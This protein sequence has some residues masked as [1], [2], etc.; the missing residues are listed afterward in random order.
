VGWRGDIHCDTVAYFP[1]WAAVLVFGLIAATD[2]VRLGIM[3]LLVSRSRP[4]LNLLVFWIGG[5]AAAVS[6]A[7]VA[8]FLFREHLLPFAEFMKSVYKSPA[9]AP[10]QIA[11]GLVLLPAA[12]LILLRARH[13]LPAGESGGEPTRFAKPTKRQTIA[14]LL[15]W[16]HHLEK[17]G[18]VGL[19]FV[20][21]A[22]S[23][24]PPLEYV[25]ALTAILASGA[26]AGTQV[27]ATVLFALVTFVILEIP[28]ASHLAWP[29]KTRAIMLS[30]HNW[31]NARRRPIFALIVG[32]AGLLMV[33]GGL[34][35]I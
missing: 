32:A 13:S 20:A 26:A 8:L 11:V 25:G 27:T 35:A 2:P 7:L 17:R 1:M 24:T 19:A 31:I 21:G 6:A 4:M 5:M 30:L 16:R 15:S 10:I 33:S 22:C 14:S 34:S 23:A 28:L 9:L 3:A 12:A 18:S 29:A